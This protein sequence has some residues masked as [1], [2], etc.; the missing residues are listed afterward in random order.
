MS[1]NP[2]SMLG[3]GDWDGAQSD[4]ARPWLAGGKG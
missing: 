4:V 3:Q 2:F 1:F